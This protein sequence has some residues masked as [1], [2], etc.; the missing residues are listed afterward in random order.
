MHLKDFELEDLK[1][2][3]ARSMAGDVKAE[4][5]DYLLYG[6]YEPFSVTLTHLLNQKAG[7][8]WTSYSHTG[9]P[10]LTSATGVKAESFNGFYDN[11]DL[12]TKI[13]EA[14]GL[15]AAVAMN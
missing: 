2:A 7:L 5:R 4:G 11:T 6:G 8:A 1:I 10:V 3:Y 13:V 12:F 14:M 15:K 9:V